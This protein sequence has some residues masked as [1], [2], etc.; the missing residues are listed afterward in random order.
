MVH[1]VYVDSSEACNDLV[2]QLGA[3]GIEADLVANRDWEIKVHEAFFE[4]RS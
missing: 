1:L 4:P 3:M 2:F